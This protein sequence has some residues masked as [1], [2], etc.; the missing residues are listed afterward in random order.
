M[1]GGGRDILELE[2]PWQFPSG[3]KSSVFGRRRVNNGFPSLVMFVHFQVL[4]FP[5]WN[6]THGF[7]YP[8]CA[9]T[10]LLSF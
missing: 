6:N 5:L 2:D 3:L 10:F 7:V 8:V 1:G 4:S 9:Y